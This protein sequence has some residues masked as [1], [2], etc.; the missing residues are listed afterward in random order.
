MITSIVVGSGNARKVIPLVRDREQLRS[1]AGAIKGYLMPTVA[2]AHIA[3]IAG[4]KRATALA[5]GASA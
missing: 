2:S 4:K 3:R 1:L 5:M